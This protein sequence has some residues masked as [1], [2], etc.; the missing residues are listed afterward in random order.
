MELLIISVPMLAKVPVGRKY[1]D[2]IGEPFTVTAIVSNTPVKSEAFS[3]EEA[4]EL[5]ADT[6]IVPS[7][8][9]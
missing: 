2:V 8:R 1:F 4:T 7:V 5:I 3:T 6:A 9:E